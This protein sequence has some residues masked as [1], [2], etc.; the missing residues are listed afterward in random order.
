[1]SCMIMMYDCGRC[2]LE[3]AVGVVIDRC[4]ERTKL[5]VK[6]VLEVFYGLVEMSF[7]N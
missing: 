4:S 1:M 6:L 3:A 2:G 5:F 7:G